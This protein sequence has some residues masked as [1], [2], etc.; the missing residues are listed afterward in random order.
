MIP[1]RKQSKRKAVTVT[2]R[3][4]V[5]AKRI[6]DSRSLQIFSTNLE[7]AYRNSN[8]SKAVL[9]AL[10]SEIASSS[11]SLNSKEARLRRI[12]GYATIVFS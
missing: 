3:D 8:L 5:T 1:K 11:L 4:K 6:N 10:K 12:Q 7:L 2:A 9:Q